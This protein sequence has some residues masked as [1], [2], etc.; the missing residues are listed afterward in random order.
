MQLWSRTLES[1]NSVVSKF[2]VDAS[3]HGL[4]N[5]VWKARERQKHVVDKLCGQPYLLTSR[6][7]HI[8]V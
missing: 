4:H 5:G 3:K 2:N 1:V 8:A 6:V 7:E